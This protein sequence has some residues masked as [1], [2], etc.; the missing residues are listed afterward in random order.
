[1]NDD[2]DDRLFQPLQSSEVVEC[3]R[4]Q[5][6]A[7]DNEPSNQVDAGE[8]QDQ[9]Q[10]RELCTYICVALVLSALAQKRVERG[11]PPFPED[12]NVATQCSSGGDD[13]YT[14]ACPY[15]LD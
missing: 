3:M 2:D 12:W 1:M 6:I 11:L 14:A 4:R 7:Q 13:D 5:Q 10:K 8:P 15:D 9:E